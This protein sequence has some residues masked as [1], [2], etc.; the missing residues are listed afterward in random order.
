MEKSNSKKLLMLVGSLF[1][2]LIFLSSY[3]SSSTSNMGTTTSIKPPATYLAIGKSSGAI[4]G[5]GTNA[6]VMLS[7]QSNSTM[8]NVNR[9]LSA[10]EANGSISNYIHIS[11]GYQVA[12]SSMDAYTLQQSIRNITALEHS[13]VTTTAYLFLP[14]NATLYVNSYP[15]NVAFSKR[16]SSISLTGIGPVGSRVNVSV[17]ALITANG[18]VYNNQIRLNYTK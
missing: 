13:N 5:Y 6:Y 8:E 3:M 14:A 12:L 17:F 7:N 16:N 1:V 2:A 4:T 10:L 15:V 18:I 11:N 9:T